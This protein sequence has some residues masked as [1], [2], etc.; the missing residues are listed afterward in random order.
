MEGK[1]NNANTHTVVDLH[2]IAMKVWERR[3]LF[4]KVW[5]I[6][7]IL[8]C[9][10][11]FPQ[12]RYYEAQVSIS[13][14]S[15][16]SNEMG[17]LAS[18]A[19]NFGVN[20]GNGSTDA[21]YPKL[22]PDLFEST[23]FLIGLL[24]INIKTTDGEIETDYYTYMKD[25]QKQ[26]I[27]TWPFR[28][29]KAWVVNLFS[30]EEQ[31]DAPTNNSKRFNP[32]KLSKKT[33]D[34]L[35]HVQKNINCSYS[36]ATDV[37]TISVKDQDPQVCALLAD[38]IKEHLQLFI[39]EYRTKKARNDYEYYKKLTAEA[40]ASYE[41]T[42]AKYASFSDAS[43]NVS[44]RSIQLK[45]EEME[46][47]MKAKYDIYTAM[48]TRLEAALAKIQERTPAFTELINAT[49]PIKPAG[50][51]RMFFVAIMLFLSTLGTMAYILRKELIEWF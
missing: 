13:P 15:S 22:Y 4:M 49:V 18:I 26:N 20:I 8:S 6:T 21:I 1:K 28:Q 25:H 40:K 38:S 35:G 47:D 31:A 19:S 14:E 23:K 24:D 42:R 3:R 44:L 12:P 43:T 45:L 9:I 30:T 37:V 11:I 51:K 36:M 32:F 34:I 50:P 7:F 33:S 48:N 17:S 2:M 5:I 41:K 46:L 10:W 39:T 27:L 29:C 16:E